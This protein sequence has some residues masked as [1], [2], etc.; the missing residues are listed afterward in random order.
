[1]T[2][3][4]QRELATEKMKKL[5]FKQST[6]AIIGLLM[7]S[8][9]NVVDTIFVGQSVGAL[10]IAALA[11]AA[12]IQMIIIS[13]AQTIGVGSSSIISR[14]L[15]AKHTHKAEA[16]LGNFFLLITIM[17]II[18]A[19]L[20]SIFLTPLLTI[21]GTTET[22][23][24]HAAEYTSII[25]WGA[26]FLCL[27]ASSNNIIRAEGNAK[28]AMYIMLLSTGV[29]LILDP[30]L[31][32]GFDMGLKGAALATVAAQIA[33]ASLAMYY[34][35]SGKNAVRIHLANLK[36]NFKIIKETFAIGS[37]SL[38]RQSAGSVVQAILNHSL[39]FYGGDLAIASFGIINRILMVIFMPMFGLVQGMQP[40]LGYN[41]GARAFKRAREAILYTMKSATIFSI[42][43]FAILMIF[44][45][46]ITKVFTTDQSL[47]E[48]SVHATRIISLGLPL[49][50]F[51]VISSG[52]YQ[53]TGK[54]MF[55]L[56]IALLRQLI[57]LTPFLLVLP[58]YLGLEG[59]FWA[60]P[61]AEIFASS[62]TG[63]LTWHTIKN[64]RGE[65][66]K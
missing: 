55:A 50:G 40:I 24:P 34:F 47:I 54:A 9:Y 8:L 66:A 6:P 58:M 64:M 41:Y 15:G 13:I 37:S 61:A 26:L 3:K 63:I 21:F 39:G 35:I 32:F 42:A 18:T 2:T 44:T 62:I 38:A 22:I 60:F 17:G 57:C 56:F 16:A 45:T 10:G 36:P 29:N 59:I 53:A 25:L 12:P 20:G 28:F 30:I 4:H 14:A 19:I 31:I 48:L 46:P 5:L 65:K 52:L 49:I 43:A 51:Q 7:M 11:I 27:T 1:M 33:S 23:M